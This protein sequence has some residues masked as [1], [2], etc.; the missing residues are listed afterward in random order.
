VRVR[1]LKHSTV[2]DAGDNKLVQPSDW[3]ADHIIEDVQISDVMGLQAVLDG[4]L[5]VGDVITGADGKSAY[6]LALEAGYVGTLEEWLQSLVGPVGKSAYQ[7]AL[8]QGYVGDIDQWLDSL[9]ASIEV[10]ALDAGKVLTNDGTT[11]S[12]SSIGDVEGFDA[13]VEDALTTIV[14]DQGDI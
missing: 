13:A 6:Q 3:N 7:L 5:N 1:H 10:T 2:P 11:T 8:E 12:W 9:K 4:K 14:V